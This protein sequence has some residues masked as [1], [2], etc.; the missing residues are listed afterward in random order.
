[1][2]IIYINYIIL[3]TV[4]ILLVTPYMLKRNKNTDEKA[5]KAKKA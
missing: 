2:L 3:L 5:N 4:T 1:M